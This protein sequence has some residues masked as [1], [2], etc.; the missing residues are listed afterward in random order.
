MHISKHLDVISACRFCFMCRHLSPVGNVTCREADTPRGRALM[1]DRIRMEP[2][3]LAQPSYLESLYAAELSA[4]CRTHCVSHY[5]EARLLLAARR[6][7]VEAGL[8]PQAVKELAEELLQVKF[9]IEGKGEVL[10]YLDPYAAKQ[11]EILKSFRAI[12]GDCAILSGGDTGKALLTLGFADEA[13]NVAAK[14]RDAVKSSGCKML[15]TSCPAS[16]HAL[17]ND[18]PLEGV[19]VK[20]SSEFLKEKGLSSGKPGKAYYLDSDYLKNYCGNLTAPRELL[21]TAGYELKPFGT[22]REESYAC[23]EGAVVYDRLNPQI[24]EKLSARIRELVDDAKSDVLVTA[25]PYTRHV[26]KLHQP[27]LNVV[28]LEE[29]ILKAKG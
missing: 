8:A 11:P 12:A 28:S 17:T 2:S 14:F 23:G 5:D 19:K 24:A 4:A 6:D 10:Y 21:A 25:S 18:F 9:K 3:R 1:L 7:A 26:L 20:H 22:N 29:A 13:E 27:D 16:Y 15:V